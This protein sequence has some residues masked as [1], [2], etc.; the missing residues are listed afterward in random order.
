MKKIIDISFVRKRDLLPLAI[1][2]IFVF[3]IHFCSGSLFAQTDTCSFNVSGKILD[4][5][6][7]LPIPNVRVIVSGTDKSALTNSKGD[8]VINNVCNES[9]TLIISCI[10][11]CNAK[12]ENHHHHDESSHIYIAQDVSELEVITIETNHSKENGTETVS[13]VVLKR[14]DIYNDPTQSLAASIADQPGVT[15]TS[16]GTNVQ[17]PVIHGLYGNRILILNNGL[18]HGFQNWG[19]DHAPEI[20]ISTA[21]RLTIVK[22]AAGVRYGPEALGGAINIENNPLYL[23]E[24]FKA[25]IGTGYQ[26]NGKGYFVNSEINQGLKNWS[27]YLGANYTL[28]GDRHA[29]SYLLTNSGKKEKSVYGGIRYHHKNW[30][31][32]VYY[33]YLDQDLALLRSSVA[34]SGNAFV[35]NINSDEP[36]F[37]RPFSYTINQPNQLAQHHLGKAE[38]HWR[39]SDNAKL[40]FKYGKQLN[41]RDEFDVR[42][43]ADRPIIDL[44]L[45]T[46]DYQLEWKHPDWLMLDGLVGVQLF[47]QFNDN[48]PGTG[49]TSVIPNYKTVRYSGFIIESITRDRNTFEAGLRLDYELNNV[50]GRQTNQAIFS[51]QFSFSNFTSSIGYVREISENSSFRTNIGTAWRTPNMSELYSFGQHGFKTTFGLLRYY[52]SAAGDVNTNQVL[53]ISEST[54]QSEKGYK[55]INEFQI[56][57]KKNTH[58]ITGYSHYIENYTF[59]RPLGVFGTIRG[60][61]PAFIF[62][63]ADALFIGLDYSW[64]RDWSKSLKGVYGI[65]YLWSRN[66]DKNEPLIN[67]PPIS[68]NYKLKWQKEKIWKFESSNLTINPSYTFQQFQAPKTISPESLIDGSVV[69]SSDSEIFDFK[70]APNGYFLLEVSWSFHWKNITGSISVNNLFNNGYRNYL[71]AMRYFANEPGRNVLFTINYLFENKKN[72]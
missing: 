70:S 64:D 34:H 19:T 43:N 28:V 53:K 7:K 41:K 47:T 51:D 58:T 26:T 54:V 55:F 14:D 67:Q 10:G 22:G 63:Q 11:Y 5:D 24:S 50:A 1:V 12:C 6:T 17:L 25:K 2:W 71:N 20:D 69:I 44:D 33:S 60:P 30:D 3:F 49:V 56:G 37:I 21:H 8:F 65:S 15:T 46:N 59:E 4:I 9:N 39:Y 61:M 48:N 31:F 35:R 45:I 57:N 23:N 38:M 32:K 40:T 16:N 72:E 62:T 29:P 27:Y 52:T 18:K 68:V 42:R 66:I 13:Q 36:S